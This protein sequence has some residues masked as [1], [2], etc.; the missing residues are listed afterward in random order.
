MRI[1][2]KPD[3]PTALWNAQLMLS[4]E[5]LWMEAP[6]RQTHRARG[7][8]GSRGEPSRAKHPTRGSSLG[9]APADVSQ[10]RPRQQVWPAAA[11]AQAGVWTEALGARGGWMPTARSQVSQPHL[12]VTCSPTCH[13]SRCCRGWNI[14]R[15]AHGGPGHP[16]F[17]GCQRGR[18]WEDVR[19]TGWWCVGAERA[20]LSTDGPEL[21]VCCTHGG[22]WAVPLKGVALPFFPLLSSQVPLLGAPAVPCTSTSQTQRD[23]HQGSCRLPAPPSTRPLP[24]DSP[25][26]LVTCQPGHC[27]GPMRL[28]PQQGDGV[29]GVWLVLRPPS[30]CLSA[31]HSCPCCGL[32]CPG[33]AVTLFLPLI[34]HQAHLAGKSLLLSHSSHASTYTEK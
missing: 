25:G 5:W 12:K 7:R 10:E 17:C 33:A 18:G 13:S 16:L 19:W 11:P 2:L 3:I 28:D 15:R 23:G 1:F 30:S 31:A 27:W 22:A 14:W 26:A 32:H 4:D 21:M 29:H 24:G 9:G 34:C 6:Q 8:E 20:A